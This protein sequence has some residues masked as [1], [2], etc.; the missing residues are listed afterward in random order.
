VVTG[1]VVAM[2]FAML[3]LAFTRTAKPSG[4]SIEELDYLYGVNNTTQLQRFFGHSCEP[5]I[6]CFCNSHVCRKVGHRSEKLTNGHWASVVINFHSLL[7]LVRSKT[8]AAEIA[9]LTP[10]VQPL[11][12]LLVTLIAQF[13]LQ[14]HSLDRQDQRSLP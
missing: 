1:I 12:V 4:I 6:H 2:G 3:A 10:R 9:A 13:L 7:I 5:A 14:I 8:A 11:V